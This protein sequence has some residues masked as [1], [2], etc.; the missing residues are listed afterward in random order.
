MSSI[1]PAN[2][3][4]LR[5]MY[6]LWSILVLGINMKLKEHREEREP[7]ERKGSERIT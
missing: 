4:N 1:E 6:M 5:N 7:Y 3:V 2:N